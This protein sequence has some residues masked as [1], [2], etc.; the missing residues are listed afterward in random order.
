MKLV[1]VGTLLAVT[2]TLSQTALGGDLIDYPDGY[3]LWAHVKSMTIHENHP[4][5]NP[6]L[7]IHHVYANDRGLSG[8]KTDRFA[9][10]SMLVFDLLASKTADG[11]SVEGDRVLI[12]VMLKDKQRFPKTNGWGYE[13]WKGDSR[14]ERLVND[15]GMSCHSCHTQQKESNYVFSQWRD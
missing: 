9:D 6:F 3:R 12:G 13:A 7:G 14:A 8:L 4:L 15:Q 11:A 5:Q 2:V 10:G 1:S